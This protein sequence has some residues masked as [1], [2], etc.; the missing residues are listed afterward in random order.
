MPRLRDI[1][2][3]GLV[4]SRF[5]AATLEL[6]L[7]FGRSGRWSH[8]WRCL[9]CGV[10][11]SSR[12]RGTESAGTAAHASGGEPRWFGVRCAPVGVS[13]K[14]FAGESGRG[15]LGGTVLLGNAM[16]AG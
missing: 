9:G 3:G 8:L 2:F 14:L 1:A 13:S 5:S 10:A 6:G 7:G 11:R 15:G 12:E 4:F 16:E